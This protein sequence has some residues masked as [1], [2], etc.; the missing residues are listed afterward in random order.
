MASVGCG[1]KQHI[2]RP[3]FQPAVKDRLERLVAG[4]AIVKTQVVTKNHEPCAFLANA[5]HE[6]RQGLQILPRDFDQHQ[7]HETFGRALD[8]VAVNGLDQRTLAH[9][10]RAP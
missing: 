4:F 6:I 9:A 5:P 2:V 10:T 3:P 1:V 7:A 8:N